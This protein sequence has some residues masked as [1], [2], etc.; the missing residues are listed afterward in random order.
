MGTQPSIQGTAKDSAW[1]D[2]RAEMVY[3]VPQ[4]SLLAW[5]YKSSIQEAGSGGWPLI[6]FQPQ[7]RSSRPT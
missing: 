2:E 6:Q 3:S 4:L 7:L 1:A 5:A